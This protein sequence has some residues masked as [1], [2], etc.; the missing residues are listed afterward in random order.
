MD[1]LGK[2]KGFMKSGGG[3]DDDKTSRFILK[4]W[5]AG[6]IKI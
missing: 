6:K 3:V 5:Q 2:K 1:T 4:E